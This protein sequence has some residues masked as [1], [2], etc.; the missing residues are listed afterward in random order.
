MNKYLA[1][2]L[3]LPFSIAFALFCV[4]EKFIAVAV[5][6]SADHGAREDIAKLLK[7]RGIECIFAGS[8][9][10]GV[11]VKKSRGREVRDIL[12]KEFGAGEKGIRLTAESMPVVLPAPPETVLPEEQ[13][14]VI[15]DLLQESSMMAPR[16]TPRKSHAD[17]LNE[18]GKEKAIPEI[19]KLLANEDWSI[20]G[21]AA[22][23]LA[24]Q[25]IKEAIPGIRKM[26]AEK[27]PIVRQFAAFALDKLGEREDI[28]EL[29]GD[30]DSQI[31][32]LAG[33]R[34]SNWG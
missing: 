12:N 26:L 18:L 27:H 11:F 23:Y 1:I 2:I 34:W 4:E 8:S 24:A 16:D 33:F 13:R 22:Y 6:P 19:I 30:S 29:I 28:K 10:C 5:V 20:R 3:I 32:A 17:L 21:N 31:R 14:R 7:Q 9:P 15:E 25:G